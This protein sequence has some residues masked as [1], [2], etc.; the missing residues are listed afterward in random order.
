MQ[1]RLVITYL[2]FWLLSDRSLFTLMA[3]TDITLYHSRYGLVTILCIY[4]VC[5]STRAA[6]SGGF[7]VKLIHRDSPSSPFYHRTKAWNSLSK[8]FRHSMRPYF[9]P[10]FH[11]NVTQSGVRADRGEYLMKLTIG[12]P[13]FDVYGIADTGSHLVWAQCLPC[14]TRNIPQLTVTCLVL[15]PNARQLALALVHLRTLAIT[16]TAMVTSH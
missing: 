14:L 5:N 3:T 16:V 8:D 9:D 2:F 12:N 4:L 13:P 15:Q 7:S 1:A 10:I 11:Q 6:N